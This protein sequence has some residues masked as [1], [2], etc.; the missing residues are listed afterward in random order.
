MPVKKKSLKDGSVDVSFA[1]QFEELEKIV[2]SFE[3]DDLD[4]DASLKQFEKGLKLADGLKKTLD[5]VENKIE[6]L[7]SKYEV[8]DE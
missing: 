5:S 1:K 7:K 2:E 4:L 3:Q 6:S 8:A